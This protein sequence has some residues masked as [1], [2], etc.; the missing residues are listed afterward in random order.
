MDMV[1]EVRQ[2]AKAQKDWTTSDQIRDKLQ[3]L[4]IAVKDGKDG[5]T[6]EWKQ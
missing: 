4:G 1:L 2:H 6:W 3:S 5:A